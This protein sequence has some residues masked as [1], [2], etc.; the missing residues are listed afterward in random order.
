MSTLLG[1]EPE[2]APSAVRQSHPAREQLERWM[3]GELS[4]SEG[5]G[6]VRHLLAGCPAC[7]Q[8]TRRLWDLGDRVPLD[9]LDGEGER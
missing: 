9:G 2:T 1:R 8:V 5:A 7:L 3:R 6:I 4:R